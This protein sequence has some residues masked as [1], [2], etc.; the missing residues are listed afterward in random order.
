M[1]NNRRWEL[2]AHGRQHLSQVQAS[3]PVPGTGE[4]LVAVEAVSLNYRDHL[5]VENGLGTDWTFPLVPGTDLAGRVVETGAGV[6][7][8]AVGD[9]VISNDI[10]GW[11]D[12]DAPTEDT[13]RATIVGRLAE[14]V[15]VDA[16]QLVAAPSSLDAVQASTLPCAALTAW[17][18]VV[19]LAHVRAGQTLVV[20]G[21][22][23]VALF[24]VQFAL[25]HGA[26]VIVTSSGQAKLD[27]LATLGPVEGIDRSRHPDWQHEVLRLTQG[28]GADHILEMAG[29]D[30]LGR[31]LEAVRVGGRISMIGL[32]GGNHFS[33]PT[34]LM[35]YKRATIAGIG[36][37]SR[38]VLEDMVRAIDALQLKPV[39]DAAYDFD[40][41][42][43]ALAHL[44]RGAFGK[45][46]V[47]VGTP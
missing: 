22:G 8:F 4:V 20:Q 7:R 18:A 44:E 37:G 30:N 5:I 46:V 32:L 10:A 31:S 39:I 45:V 13:N 19:E 29:G 3:R 24:A 23:G 16:Q 43:Q 33:G 21:T 27:R 42:P 2:A 41:L 34:G 25:A 36:V 47:K 38:R 35:L 14:Y 11:V 26:R 6:T 28:R 12:G 9:R 15:V 40:A 1:S 17:M